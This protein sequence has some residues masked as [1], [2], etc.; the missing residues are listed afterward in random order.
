M[1]P[2]SS[3]L[4]THRN[5]ATGTA[6]GEEALSGKRI[7]LQPSLSVRGW[8][9]NAGSSALENFIALDDATV[10][11]RLKHA[12]ALFSGNSKMSELGFGLAGDT[13]AR[14]LSAGEADI[15]LVIDFMGE[16]RVAAACAGWFGFKPS[17]GIVSRYGLIGLVPSME[18]CGVL[19]RGPG[20]VLDV[21]A[22]IAG[23][24]ANDPS[25]PDERLPEFVLGR[26]SVKMPCT[27][28]VLKECLDML[29]E[30][31]LSAFRK[32]LKQLEQIGL[33]VREVG[34][35]EFH[36]V[37]SVHNAIAA[38]EASSSAGKYDGVRYG[39]RSASAKNWNDMYLNSRGEAFGSLIKA[40]LF[41]GAYFQFE[42]YASFENACRI[43][44]RLVRT[45][46]DLLGNV[47]V[48]VLPTRRVDHDPADAHTIRQLY[49]AFS[50]TLLTNV[51][52]QPTLQVP[53]VAVD[54][55]V[56]TGLQLIGLRLDD[57]LLLSIG[58]K[59]LL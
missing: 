16:A 56:D 20:D 35:P 28:G 18:C 34:F 26:G 52:G 36:L 22:V 23:K 42:N 14:L 30:T 11:S 59:L 3:E 13:T 49:D 2:M 32:G 48:L 43:R 46:H 33:S 24:D 44:H 45:V 57:T 19:A 6:P 27:A 39:H 9:C 53:A 54:G 37:R 50:L 21:M 10:V 8:P 41:Q 38:V 51:T 4:Y 7:V 15:G 5:A 29:T 58:M 12:G 17:F 31:E 55:G 47:D 40:F 1:V 25:L